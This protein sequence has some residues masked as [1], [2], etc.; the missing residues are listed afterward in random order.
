[1]GCN[2][3]GLNKREN[4]LVLDV[5]RENKVGLGALLETKI[6]HEN[7]KDVIA[8]SFPNWDFY[9]SS[10]ISNRIILIWQ[11]KF[12]CVEV[13]IEDVQFIHCKVK[14]I[15]LME[16]FFFTTVYGSNVLLERRNLFEQL[17]GHGLLNK[18]WLILGDFNA[19]FGFQDREGGKQILAKDIEDAQTWLSQGQVEELKGSGS[20]FTWSNKHDM[21][22]RVYSKL[23]R[24]FINED[25][26]DQFPNTEAC[27]KWDCISDHSYCIVKSN[28]IGNVEVKSFRY[29]NHWTL[30]SNF[31]ETVLS[32]WNRGNGAKTVGDVGRKL[33]RLKHVLKKFNRE[34]VGDIVHLYHQSKAQFI[35]AQ[36]NLEKDPS[37]SILHQIEKSKGLEYA[38]AIK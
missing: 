17:A 18:P 20:Y 9:S 35:S 32:C 7:V 12:V 15:G 38:A 27:F 10:T 1:M 25:W 11:S 19:M 3:R 4:R 5:C 29:C 2:V 22:S 33:L 24:V 21:G 36:E 37:N 28:R 8:S 30:H 13:L 26:L 34:E 16:E 31:R 23:D 6:K 14:G